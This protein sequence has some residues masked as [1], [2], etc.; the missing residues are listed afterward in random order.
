MAKLKS[1][2]DLRFS[3]PLSPFNPFC[4]GLRRFRVAPLAL[5]LAVGVE[6]SAPAGRA[7]IYVSLVSLAVLGAGYERLGCQLEGIHRS[8]I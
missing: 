1:R 2:T 3:A 5:L 7:L 8:P 4:N 6:W